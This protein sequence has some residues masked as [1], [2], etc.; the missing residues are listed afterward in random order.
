MR[1]VVR[2]HKYDEIIRR[3]DLK[4]R[5]F[6]ACFKSMRTATV[7]IL[8]SAAMSVKVLIFLKWLDCVP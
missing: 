6:N 2:R 7:T 4:S 5:F 8:P 1:T 3:Q